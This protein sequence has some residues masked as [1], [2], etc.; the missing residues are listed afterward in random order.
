MKRFI[1]HI[2]HRLMRFGSTYAGPVA[3]GNARSAGISR[4]L[5]QVDFKGENKV[6]TGCNFN[7]AIE[8]GKYTTLGYNSTFH[9][10]ITIGNYC[11]LGPHVSIITTNHPVHYL[12][13]YINSS[14]FEGEL[15]SLKQNKPVIIGNDVWIGQN[16]TIL[17]GVTVGDGA[18]L[19]A[20]AIVT[21]DVA[22]FS[23][24]AG[25]PAKH[26][27]FRFT[28][29]VQR[30]IKELEWWYKSK[31]ALEELKPLF[32]KNLEGKNTLY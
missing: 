12:S 31:E 30:E 22:D 8:I 2:I 18:I 29:S 7:G 26:V 5:Q 11:Q 1:Q 28:E 16:V 32:F 17:G 6:A 13:T 10:T 4:G 25:S 14:L 24:V 21:K 15:T 23:I 27:K 9:G 3:E 20:G 19:A